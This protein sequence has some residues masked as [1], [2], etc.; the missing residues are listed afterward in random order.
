MAC[1]RH[2]TSKLPQPRPPT[3]LLTPQ[4]SFFF[5]T[6]LLRS[7]NTPSL[8]GPAKIIAPPP[9][10]PA[11]LWRRKLRHRDV[12]QFINTVACSPISP[13]PPHVTCPLPMPGQLGDHWFL[14]TFPLGVSLGWK[15]GS[16]QTDRRLRTHIDLLGIRSLNTYSHLRKEPVRRGGCPHTHLTREETG[17]ANPSD[18][19]RPH[20][21]VSFS[22]PAVSFGMKSE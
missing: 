16:G 6:F 20:G 17:T 18:S 15:A 1:L 14:P 5:Q 4:L 7:G 2:C 9:H 8:K 3:F 10:M 22:F 13:G 12:K 11:A 19:R 21:M